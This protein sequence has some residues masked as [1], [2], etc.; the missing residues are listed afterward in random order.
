MTAMDRLRRRLA[1]L[2]DERT[3]SGKLRQK[4]LAAHF[5]KSEAWLT[6]I[7]HG[8]RGFRIVD[9]DTLAEFFHVPPSE[10]VRDDAADLIEV[11]PTELQLLRRLRRASPE[12]RLAILT[13]AGLEGEP[14]RTPARSFR[15][16]KP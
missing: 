9:L 11:T 6:N 7:L 3:H 5:G 10:F 8:K 14:Q 13:L 1:A 2:L 4:A 15:K 12:F 16:P